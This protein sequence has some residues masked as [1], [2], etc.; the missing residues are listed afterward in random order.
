M[1]IN[2]KHILL[3]AIGYMFFALGI[4]LGTIAGNDVH[5]VG[6]ACLVV[7]FVLVFLLIKV[8]QPTRREQRITERD[9][10]R[11]ETY[12]QTYIDANAEE[13]AKQV[14]Q[15]QEDLERGREEYQKSLESEQ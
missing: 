14:R 6:P 3:A 15:Y 12:V 2:N 5:I 1:K 8:S 9:R 11:S 10:A 13:R 7:T 4:A